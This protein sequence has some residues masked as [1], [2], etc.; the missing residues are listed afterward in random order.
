MAKKLTAVKIL[1]NGGV[2]ILPTDTIYGLVG[3]ALNKN[4]VEKIYR[5]KKRTPDK[6]FIILI[7]KLKDLNH[8]NIRTSRNIKAFLQQIWPSPVSVIL[9]C[10]DNRFSYLH[11]GSKSLAFRM[12][13][14]K[15][16]L[17]I[18]KQVGPLVA[19]SANP[20]GLPPAQTI[21]QA[22]K[23]FES[24]VDFYIDEGQISGLPST[25]IQIKNTKVKIL[26]QGTFN[27]NSS[28]VDIKTQ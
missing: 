25:L 18:I 24:Q 11:R 19:P 4:V 16:L 26:R 21:I 17:D 2:I 15:S 6:P 12:P 28:F 14:K 23:Y 10:P 1:K 20:E 7:S 3:Q 27:L 5:L 8:F 9:D 13:D 22:K